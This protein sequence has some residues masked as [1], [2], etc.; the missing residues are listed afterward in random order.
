MF[1]LLSFVV[2]G[3]V[4]IIDFLSVFAAFSQNEIICLS[5]EWAVGVFHCVCYAASKLETGS[6]GDGQI[7]SIQLHKLFI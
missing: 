1:V 5:F 4:V 2:A 6:S 3:D 7:R